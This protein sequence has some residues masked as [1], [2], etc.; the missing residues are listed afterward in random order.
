MKAYVLVECPE[1]RDE[2]EI[3]AEPE[4]RGCGLDMGVQGHQYCMNLW[5]RDDWTRIY[6]RV[7][8]AY[9]L[10]LQPRDAA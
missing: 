10:S 2:I 3:L 7:S 1:C 6:E 8:E 9:E 5:D 4:R